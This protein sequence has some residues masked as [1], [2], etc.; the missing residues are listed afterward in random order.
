MNILTTNKSDD[1]T[2]FLAMSK[3]DKFYNDMAEH[4]TR[5]MMEKQEA[6]RIEREERKKT[7]QNIAQGWLEGR[8]SHPKVVFR[9]ESYF[10]KDDDKFFYSMLKDEYEKS[11]NLVDNIM[12]SILHTKARIEGLTEEKTYSFFN[13]AMQAR[14]KKKLEA[15]KQK[16]NELIDNLPKVLDNYH[17]MIVVM[18]NPIIDGLSLKEMCLAF[19]K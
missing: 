8:L 7:L 19:C 17:L 6:K 10:D 15:E 4:N 1:N 14:R 5:I 13:Q 12:D 2:N 9:D 16:L 18:E 3:M 11:Y